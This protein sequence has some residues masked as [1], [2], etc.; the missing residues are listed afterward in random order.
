MQSVGEVVA[1]RRTGLR[2]VGTE[3]SVAE[4]RPHPSS[5][6]SVLCDGGRAA[7][8]AGSYLPMDHSSVCSPAG[9]GLV[10]TRFLTL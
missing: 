8:L 2:E 1:W 9:M 4:F 5:N 7:G 3:H 6:S 10:S